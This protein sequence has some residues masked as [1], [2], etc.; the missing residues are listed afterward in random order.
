MSKF[1]FT[2]YDAEH[3][4]EKTGTFEDSFCNGIPKG[5]R[6]LKEA[7]EKNI[8]CAEFWLCGDPK[9]DGDYRRSILVFA[10][11]KVNAKEVSY[12]VHQHWKTLKL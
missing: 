7:F 9:E 6:M 12:F 11:D 4:K 1:E 2:T 8:D 10:F 3:Q 5:R